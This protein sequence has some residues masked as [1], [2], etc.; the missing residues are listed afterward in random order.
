MVAKPDPKGRLLKTAHHVDGT[1]MAVLD[2]GATSTITIMCH[3]E[4]LPDLLASDLAAIQAHLMTRAPGHFRKK[5]AK[6][7]R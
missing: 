1:S 7:P 5:R 4:T 2:N 3:S 6:Q